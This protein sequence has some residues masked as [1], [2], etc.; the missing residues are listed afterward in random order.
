MILT[1]IVLNALFMLCVIDSTNIKVGK[2]EIGC[3]LM[4]VNGTV[5]IVR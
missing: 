3:W 5:A 2:L 1:K 4:S